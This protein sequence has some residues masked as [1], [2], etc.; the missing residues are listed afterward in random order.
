LF[1]GTVL[2]RF[3]PGKSGHYTIPDGTTS[4]GDDAFARSFLL[5]S[6]TIPCSVTSI[7]ENAFEN[8]PKLTTIEFKDNS[9]QK[10]SHT[11]E[12]NEK[13]FAKSGLKEAVFF[14]D[15]VSIE[16]LAYQGS[17]IIKARIPNTVKYIGDGAFAECTDLKSIEV[18]PNPKNDNSSYYDSVDGVLF[19]LNHTTLI[20]YPAGKE[21]DYIVPDGVSFIARSSFRGSVYLT[22]ITIGESVEFIGS[23]AFKDCGNLKYVN[24]LGLN[25]PG[26]YGEDIL[27][28]CDNLTTIKVPDNYTSSYFCGIKLPYCVGCSASTTQVTSI[29][30]ICMLLVSVFALIK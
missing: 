15:T 5:T 9:G 13:L 20:Q 7:G 27:A 12:M 2:V 23:K 11:P 28:G 22:N 6:L 30:V 17:A 18:E 24:Y 25:D 21:G 4:I 19:D 14:D 29:V 26:E 10:C 16:R 1:D 3:P 8:T